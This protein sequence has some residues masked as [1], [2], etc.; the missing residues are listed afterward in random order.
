MK[1]AT[2]TTNHAL[3]SS[4]STSALSSISNSTSTSAFT[5]LSTSTSY[6][7]FSTI[8]NSSIQGKSPNYCTSVQYKVL[9]VIILFF[10]VLHTFLVV[11]TLHHRGG[12]GNGV[13]DE[14][15]TFTFTFFSNM[16]R[17]GEYSTYLRS[18]V[19]SPTASIEGLWTQ[20]N[21][22]WQHWPGVGICRNSSSLLD[23]IPHDVCVRRRCLY[24]RSAQVNV[25]LDKLLLYQHSDAMA[26]LTWTG[27][28]AGC[29]QPTGG[30]LSSENKSHST[31]V[32]FLY[33]LHNNAALAASS[34]L[35]VF[36]TAHEASSV[37]FIIVDDGS[38]EDMWLVDNLLANMKYLF[39]TSIVRIRNNSP[40]G[41][42]KSNN[43]GMKQAA[44]KFVML[45]N[46]DVLVLPGWLAMLLRTINQYPD[47]KVGMVG[48]IMLDKKG[49]ISEAGGGMFKLGV[50]FNSG[51]GSF[52]RE[53]PYQHARV[54]DY[55]SAACLLVRRDLFLQLNLFD[56][57]FSPAYYEDTDA[58]FVHLQH[59]YQTKLQPL[60]V[61][62]HFEGSSYGISGQSQV[63][64]D[65]MER[66]SKHFIK[67]HRDALNNYC[68]VPKHVENQFQRIQVQMG[69]SFYRQQ[70]RILILED[71]VPDP[72]RDAE[73]SR[74]IEL[75]HILVELGYSITF[76][77]QP[78]EGRSVQH[79]LPLLAD[80]I[81]VVVPGSLHDM[82]QR[83]SYAS[84][85]PQLAQK[86]NFCPW[87]AIIIARRD[88]CN[89]H[90]A[91]VKR[92][93]PHTPIIFD[94]VNAHFVREMHMLSTK[95]NVTDINQITQSNQQAKEDLTKV[96]D[97][98][99]M[100]LDCITA[101]NITI[102]LSSEG[103]HT[104]K[105]MLDK[106]SDIRI[107]SNIYH[108]NHSVHGKEHS[109]RSGAI[110]VG[111]ICHTA[112]AYAV[113]FI[114]TE[115]L[116]DPTVFPLGF[117]MHIV[118]S[119]SRICPNKILDTAE[120]HPLVVVHRDISKEELLNLHNQ[121]M[122]V[123]S[124]LQY[125][126]VVH[127]K[128]NYGLFHGVP[129]LA[130]KEVAEGMGLKDKG[131]VL[132]AETGKEFVHQIIRL[133]ED[134][135]LFEQ[136]AKSGKIMIDEVFGRDAAKQKIKQALLDVGAPAK[137]DKFSCPFFNEYQHGDIEGWKDYWVFTKSSEAGDQP[138]AL[139]PFFP[140]LAYDKSAFTRYVGQ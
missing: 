115:I 51:R 106:D 140:T 6:S 17:K 45:L 80:G 8:N 32:S 82:A 130:S 49:R 75:L 16:F 41:Y 78:V 119:R 117:K 4:T 111:D 127:A 34:I 121:V 28:S 3:I 68:P 61:V 24:S 50:P 87:D 38:D 70:N 67:K 69:Q 55:I 89:R 91:D 48:P 104:L 124:P 53:L 118:W 30:Q 5:S 26:R 60:S 52:P 137:R 126:A 66:N 25:D 29:T 86:G 108:V 123:L 101:S 133:H 103:Q 116:K 107:I 93:C 96:L 58:A 63:K 95:Y 88:V 81:N 43:L 44:G 85:Y 40:L 90:I 105:K 139:F 46:S 37:E 57:V 21:A 122:A 71:V 1:R 128:V 14:T 131:N 92:L 125:D 112:N 19:V 9:G 120:S 7:S 102:V 22:P 74:L 56:D 98:Q 36:R 15:F 47:E 79:I 114:I 65:L 84:F 31:E 33:T 59:G 12:E 42:G 62:L 27:D 10:L 94:T 99:K 11:T 113:N 2:S 83:A 18:G 13:R 97:A 135:A 64:D 20:V 77:A 39:G 129:V 76:E 73:S 110:F 109:D 35:E 136:L 132:L 23:D 54:V 134:K 72:D 100:E 138:V